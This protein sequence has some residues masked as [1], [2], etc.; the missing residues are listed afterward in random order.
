ML[1]HHAL[2]PIRSA[3]F[4]AAVAAFGLLVPAKAH[5]QAAGSAKTAATHASLAAKANDI[6]TVKKHLHHALNC[7]EGKQ[8]K[9]YDAAAGDPCKGVGASYAS[10]SA[11]E[12]KVQQAVRLIDV[13]ES[14]DNLAA[15]QHVAEAVAAI[16][17]QLGT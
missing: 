17:G 3:L 2:R 4:V 8:G 5:A 1:V 16:L 6:A 9:G 10:G 14:L 11:D 7:L 13:G 15:T 12:A